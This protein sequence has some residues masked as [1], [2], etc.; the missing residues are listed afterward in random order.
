VKRSAAVRHC[1]RVLD[2]GLRHGDCVGRLN[3]FLDG[4]Y[5]EY[6]SANNIRVFGRHVYLFS[7]SVLITVIHLPRGMGKS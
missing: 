2:V 3:R 4:L 5:L 6:G 1:L 7:G